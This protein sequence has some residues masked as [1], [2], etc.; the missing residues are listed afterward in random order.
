MVANII[1]VKNH[2]FEILNPNPKPQS[3]ILNPNQNPIFRSQTL[4]TNVVS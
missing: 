1:F 2:Q 3:Q 4:K